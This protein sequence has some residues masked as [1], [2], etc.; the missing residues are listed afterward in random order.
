MAVSDSTGDSRPLAGQTLFLFGR[1]QG[2][3]RRR[4][5]QLVRLRGGKLVNKPAARITIIALGHSAVSNVLPD[6]RLRLPAGL[7]ESAALISEQELRRRLGLL[8]PPEVVD[9]SLGIA[10]LERLSGLTPRLLSCLALFDV[11]EPVDERYAYRDVV[12]AREAGRLLARGV[13]LH[14]V[15]EAAI[16]LRRRGSHLSETKLAESPSGELLAELSGQLAELNGQLTMGLE[17]EVRS[18]D[19]VV[20]AAERA[21]EH[22]DLAAAENLYTTALRADSNDPVI[23]FNLGNVFD[24]QGRSAE[25]KIAWQISVARDPAFA[26]AWYNLALAAEDEQHTDLAVAEY[27]RAMQARPDYPDAHFNLALLLTKLDRYADA[28]VVWERFLELAPNSK[29]AA[30][31]KRAATLCRMEMKQQQPKTG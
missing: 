25:A 26:E 18:I 7:P 28:L 19:D 11:I 2:V 9:R 21:E 3:T 20:A 13:A 14:R 31:A 22:N 29:Q 16:T 30:T 24:A 23:P 27:R 17:Q 10:D 5:D 8:R 1:V 12:A 4:L 15:L 6:G